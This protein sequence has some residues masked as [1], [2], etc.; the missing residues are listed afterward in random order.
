MV[1][2]GL[3]AVMMAWRFWRMKEVKF[4]IEC[5]G[6][7]RRME[8]ENPN[9]KRDSMVFELDIRQGANIVGELWEYPNHNVMVTGVAGASGKTTMAEVLVD[10]ISDEVECKKY[11]YDKPMPCVI[12]SPKK[13]PKGETIDFDLAGRFRILDCSEEMIN[14]FQNREAFVLAWE[15]LVVNSI[16]NFGITAS[17]IAEMTGEIL[18]ERVCRNWND[19]EGNLE[20]LRKKKRNEKIALSQLNW[21]STKIKYLKVDATVLDIPTSN[22]ILY[23]GSLPSKGRSFYYEAYLQHLVKKLEDNPSVKPVLVCD[24]AHI[25]LKHQASIIGYFLRELRTH[26]SAIITISQNLDDCDPQLLQFSKIFCGTQ[27]HLKP[28]MDKPTIK[29]C[30]GKLPPYHFVDYTYRGTDNV[31]VYSLSQKAVEKINQ[32]KQEG[33]RLRNSVSDAV[34]VQNDAVVAVAQPVLE[35]KK[36]EITGER[37]V[38]MLQNDCMIANDISKAMGIGRDDNRRFQV[39]SMIEK[40][41]SEK[42]IRKMLYV[43]E[44]NSKGERRKPRKYFYISE[45]RTETTIH[46]RLVDDV[47]KIVETEGDTIIADYK[48]NQ[49]WDIETA[50]YYCDAVTGLKNGNIRD[51]VEKLKAEPF[52]KPTIFVCVNYEVMSRQQN[53][54]DSVEGIEG[55]FY[56]YCLDTLADVIRSLK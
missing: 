27:Q 3:G 13:F 37:I 11:G 10:E 19:F 46:L 21:I 56:C 35:E 14:V 31:P 5:V 48:S 16:D 43:I 17:Q 8:N 6:Y 39:K 44:N 24:E 28:F 49:S 54:L 9:V 40:L 7:F 4:P 51:D 32:L 42:K 22:V 38:E 36:P 23:L 41:L 20:Q 25:I 33:L 12:F 50:K 2:A 26:V 29:E 52:K 47:K 55:R 45:S 53:A 1:F 18:D 15:V 34:K 30:V